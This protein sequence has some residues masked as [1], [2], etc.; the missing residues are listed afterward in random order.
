LD[1]KLVILFTVYHND[2]L[3]YIIQSIKSLHDQDYKTF[4][5]LV[6]VDGQIN[7]NIHNFLTTIED[8]RTSIINFDKN[9]GLAAVLNDGIEYSKQKGYEFIGRMDADDIIPSK[10]LLHQ[11]KYLNT[12]PSVSVVGTNGYLIDEEGNVVSEKRMKPVIKL[13]D[14]FF[15]PMV[16]HASVIFRTGF[17]D[18]VGNYDSSLLRSQDYDLWFRAL[19]KKV[20][21]H[22]IQEPLYYIRINNNLINR[23]KEEQYINLY[24]KKRHL[25]GLYLIISAIPNVLIIILPVKIFQIAVKALFQVKHIFKNNRI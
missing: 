19:K 5:I 1:N 16:I 14:L 15:R 7:Q 2:K 8:S 9:R 6:L 23:R 3:D 13:K 20:V 22:N 11:M 25:K 10:R 17:F 21:I 24:I 4:D 18:E 12:H